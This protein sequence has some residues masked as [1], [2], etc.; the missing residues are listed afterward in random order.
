M[1]VTYLFPT[2]LPHQVWWN[3]PL[4]CHIPRAKYC[5]TKIQKNVFISYLNFS[6]SSKT[7][8]S[9][10]TLFLSRY[11][12]IYTYIF[13]W[14]GV[15]ILYPSSH[16]RVRDG[17]TIQLLVDAGVGAPTYW[18]VISYCGTVIAR[19]GFQT[20]NDARPAI[21]PPTLHKLTDF[22]RSKLTFSAKM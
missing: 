21:V 7:L 16:Q 11:F 19:A 1:N 15:C 3:I 20:Q 2:W 10:S 17:S 6:V 4:R 9:S 22:G 8:V 18:F 13:L 12:I 14:K 5:G